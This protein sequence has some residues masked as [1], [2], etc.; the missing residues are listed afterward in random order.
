M[1]SG[2]EQ[3]VGYDIWEDSKGGVKSADALRSNRSAKGQVG[4]CLK[5]K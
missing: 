1:C 4:V 3:M 5:V 2:H